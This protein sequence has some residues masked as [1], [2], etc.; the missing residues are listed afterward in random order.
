MLP[1]MGLRR[2]GFWL[3]A[4][5]DDARFRLRGDAGDPS[6]FQSPILAIPAILAIQGVG[7]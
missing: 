2:A 1:I 6:G 5:G 3:V 4:V 7:W